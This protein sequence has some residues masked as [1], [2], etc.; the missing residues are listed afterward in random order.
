M[1]RKWRYRVIVCVGV[2]MSSLD[3]FI[4]NIAFPAIAQALRRRLAR[5]AL[6]G[7]S[8]RYAIVFAALLVP[9]GR[10]ADAFGRKRAFLLGLAVFVPPARPA[11]GA[12]RSTSLVAARV[13]QAVGRRADAADLARPDAARVRPRTSAHVAIGVWAA[14]RRDRRRRR[15][16]ARRAAR[17]GR[18]AL[19]VPRQR[20][21]RP[22][23]RSSSG[24]RT[25]RERREPDAA[26]P[27]VLG[28]LALIVGDRRRSSW[29]SS[30]VR[31]GA[32]AR[33]RVLGCWRCRGAAAGDLVA[34]RT[35]PAPVVDPAML[36]VRSFGARGRRV[37]AVLRRLRRD[38]A[39]GRAVPHRAVARGR[40]AGR[41]DARPRPGDGRDLQHPRRAPRRAA[42]AWPRSGRSARRC[43]RGVALVHHAA[44][45]RARLPRA[46]TSRA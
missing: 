38:A 46:S 33:P 6:A 15:A 36:R 45:A 1:Q 21:R 10:W 35:Q 29:R 44:R 24:S 17:A 2:F 43:S 31:T 32:G 14:T 22:R 7:C 4:V 39:D 16:A 19:G 34:L 26:R 27:D 42:S 12:R 30:R 25:L 11:R 37:G 40:A 23:R 18:L 28:A 9:A 8:T 5:L 13:V 20:S 3:L 41:A